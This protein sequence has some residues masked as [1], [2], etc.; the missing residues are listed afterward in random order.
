M[1]AEI[2]YGLFHNEK[3]MKEDLEYID[4]YFKGGHSDEDR[5]LFEK[6]ILEDPEFAG[7]LSFYI[8]SLHAVR[9]QSD[10]EKKERFRSLYVSPTRSRSR[11]WTY[12]ASAAVITG[13]AI[14]VYLLYPASDAGKLADDYIEKNLSS[15][16]VLMSSSKDSMENAIALY[17]E[18]RIEEAGRL[19]ETLVISHPT[20]HKAREYAGVVSLRLGNYDKALGYFESLSEMT[21][22]YANPGKFY[23]SLTLL[24]RNAP[25]D[26]K[27]AKTLLQQIV[28]EGAAKEQAARE[29]L[30]QL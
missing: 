15:L 5:K 26:V 7:E 21:E 28:K 6:R 29:L 2:A 3:N 14:G 19:F 9:L 10:E 20:D 30:R 11:L 25:G 8:S 18:N 23:V 22:L 4:D 17:N 1:P 12:I 24:K 27:R 16:G 13:L